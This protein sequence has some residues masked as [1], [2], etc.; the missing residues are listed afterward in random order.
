[1]R[2]VHATVLEIDKYNWQ[3]IVMRFVH[4]TVLEIEWNDK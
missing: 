2:Y 1:M 3:R 4:A